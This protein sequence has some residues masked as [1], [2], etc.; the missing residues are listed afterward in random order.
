VGAEYW[1]NR[2]KARLSKVGEVNA[3]QWIVRRTS[4]L[5]IFNLRIRAIPLLGMY[6]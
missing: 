3:N 4:C 2:L 5:R 1:R 6:G